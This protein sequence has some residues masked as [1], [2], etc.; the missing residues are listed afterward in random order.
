MSHA[1]I[2]VGGRS[3]QTQTAV[4]RPHRTVPRYSPGMPA[5][6]WV[7]SRSAARTQPTQTTPAQGRRA[8]DG[9]QSDIPRVHRSSRWRPVR[10]VPAGR[11]AQ[12]R[13]QS[14]SWSCRARGS[15]AIRRVYLAEEPLAADSRSEDARRCSSI[16]AALWPTV[17]PRGAEHQL[18]D[19]PPP[20]GASSASS[21]R[22]DQ[23]QAPHR[24]PPAVARRR[25]SGWRSRGRERPR[26]RSCRLQAGRAPC[27]ATSMGS[28]RTPTSQDPGQVSA[29]RR[30]VSPGRADSWRPVGTHSARTERSSRASRFP[31]RD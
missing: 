3:R 11:D 28:S 23:R 7:R 27:R 26:A 20:A 17:I 30:A 9:G 8:R 2:D 1:T 12:A 29:T 6:R 24:S 31:Y 10:A 22:V 4:R 18:D 21:S 25:S 5:P 19:P 16:A 14:A 15:V 13:V